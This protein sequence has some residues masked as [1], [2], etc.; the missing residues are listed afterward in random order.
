MA[1]LFFSYSHKDEKLRD[2]LET[3][4]AVL[5]REGLVTTWHDRRILSGDEFDKVIDSEMESA[6]VIVLLLSPDFLASSYIN[7]I[8]VKR[9]IERHQQ[10]LARIIPVILK[11]CDWQRTF[12]G[13]LLVAPRDGKPVVRWSDRN[14]AFL[15]V[16]KRIRAAILK[17]DTA[18]DLVR[19]VPT[20]TKNW[21]ERK[22]NTG[23]SSEARPKGKQ[24]ELSATPTAELYQ[25]AADQGHAEAQYNLGMLYERGDGVPMVLS[26]A[27]ELYQ[28]AADQ[29][30]VEAQFHLGWLY[31]GVK[32]VPMDLGKSVELYQKAADQG[33]AKAQIRLGGLYQVKRSGVPQQDLRKAAELYQKAANQGNAWGQVSLAEL[34]ERGWGMPQDLRKAAE[35]YQKAANQGLAFAQAHLGLLYENGTG[36]L[37]NLGKAK[38]FYQK[39]ADQGDSFAISQLKELSVATANDAT[40]PVKSTKTTPGVAPVVRAGQLPSAPLEQGRETSAPQR[41]DDTTRV[42]RLM[43]RIKNNPLVA[44]VVVLGIVVIG[45][46]KFTDALD[47]IYNFF[48]GSSK[49]EARAGTERRLMIEMSHRASE[50]L[51]QLEQDQ[52]YLRRGAQYQSSAIYYNV[53]CHLDN[54]CPPQGGVSSNYS[55]F[56]E[57]HT[58]TFHS[59]IEN[60]MEIEGP[61]TQAQL[62]RAWGAFDELDN[63]SR[64]TDEQPSDTAQARQRSL[65]A[66]G[67]A[68]EIIKNKVIGDYLKSPID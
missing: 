9:A 60:L 29:G 48:S 19:D 21:E 42:E 30:H 61:A 65:E 50:A 40:T 68:T 16:V 15:D 43:R 58:S 32:G 8:E 37:K 11:P 41:A 4:L 52:T 38:E 35:L 51:K 28:K 18:Q 47:K 25:K 7:N 57:Y 26:V 33:H 17:P 54:S 22:D 13:T 31:E 20:L 59:L 14:E 2:Q 64:K 66:V 12:F 63:L 44:A 34:Y 56:S 53:V 55:V 3:H 1:K 45:I 36:V 10:G 39:A 49:T 46:A 67:N 24:A 23:Q 5:K 6:D 62:K 27:T